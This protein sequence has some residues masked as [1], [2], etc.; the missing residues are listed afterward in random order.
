MRVF[1]VATDVPGV[2]ASGP[3]SGVEGFSVTL[4]CTR[5]GGFPE[6]ILDAHWLKDGGPLISE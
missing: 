5:L 2:E 3:G 4:T 1:A 6:D